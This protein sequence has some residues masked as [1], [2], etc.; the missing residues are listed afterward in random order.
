MKHIKF[1]AWDRENQKMV[2]DNWNT[3]YFQHKVIAHFNHPDCMQFTGLKDDARTEIYEGDIL[4]TW[5]DNCYI[6]LQVK[7]IDVSYDPELGRW[8]LGASPIS[9][10]AY[11][12]KEVVGNIYENPELLEQP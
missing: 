7:L 3:P 6:D 9:A 8:A 11:R 12:H 5:Q 4:R 1:R 2:Y 10:S